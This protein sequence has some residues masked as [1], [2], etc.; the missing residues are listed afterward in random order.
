[1]VRNILGVTNPGLSGHGSDGNEEV[2]RILQISRIME[3]P[4]LIL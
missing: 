2:V 4:H 1:M 3:P